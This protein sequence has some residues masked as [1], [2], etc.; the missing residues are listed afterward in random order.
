[1]STMDTPMNPAR[2]RTAGHLALC[3]RFAAGPAGLGLALCCLLLP[4][5]AGAQQAGAS[6]V[7]PVAAPGL[8]ASEA[9]VARP[10]GSGY[11]SRRVA[12]AVAGAA[13]QPAAGHADDRGRSRVSPSIWGNRH[14]AGRGGGRGRR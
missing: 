8:R 1:M 2:T 7:H 6:D 10:Y 9:A 14:M 13:S 4:G 3:G 11:E 5:T 12:D